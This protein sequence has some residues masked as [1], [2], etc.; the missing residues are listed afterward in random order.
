MT[1]QAKTQLFVLELNE[2]N[3]DY[4]K[5]YMALGDLPTFSAFIGRHGYIETVSEQTYDNL[6][7]WIQWVT[8]HTGKSF[9]EHGVFRLGDIV[10]QD[11]PQIWEQVEAA[12]LKVG[13]ISPMNAK[14]RLKQPA[15]FIPDPWTQTGIVAP[16]RVQRLV[17]AIA[18]GVNDNATNRLYPGTALDLLVGVIGTAR[19]HNYPQYLRLGLMARSQSWA[20]ALFLDLL[21]ADLF[22]QLV[23]ST[24]PVF[25]T[26]FVN[27]AAHVQHHYMFSSS[28]YRGTQVNP[29]WYLPK[30]MDPLREVYRLYDNVLGDMLRTFPEARLMLATGLHQDPHPELTYYWRLRAHDDFL[31]RIGVHCERVEPRMSRDFL[32]VCADSDKAAAAERRLAATQSADGTPLFEVDNRGSDLFVMLT[33]PHD[34]AEDMQFRIGNE[35]FD[36]LRKDVAFVAIKN[37]RHN[38]I[39]YFADSGLNLGK[40]PSRIELK[41]LPE[42]ILRALDIPSH[43][44][45]SMQ[46]GA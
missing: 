37:G 44:D 18:R 20:K 27:A 23:Q 35:S 1:V 42:R 40:T 38:G 46:T 14:Y 7:P 3:F 6:E 30:D 33:Y 16:A 22:C 45:T 21:L 31:R 2:V 10:N 5:H 43:A 41:T 19:L 34:I 9:A 24:Q 32:V 39:G 15:F 36:G 17:A 26:L 12:G 11:L 4:L 13:A 28:A 29:D 25:A 8:A